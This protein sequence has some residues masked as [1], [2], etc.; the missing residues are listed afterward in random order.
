MLEKI[1]SPHRTFRPWL[2]QRLNPSQ[3][4]P[5]EGPFSPLEFK[6]HANELLGQLFSLDYMGAAE[7]ESGAI[8]RCIQ[9]VAACAEKKFLCTTCKIKVT[10]PHF[11]PLPFGTNEKLEKRWEQAP[12]MF[13]VPVHFLGPK[14]C[15]E[16]MVQWVAEND[17][18]NSSPPL[19]ERTRFQDTTYT[20]QWCRKEGIQPDESHY[21]Y[22][23]WLEISYGVF[24]FL[25]E[26]V[27]QKTCNLF[28]VQN[29][30]TV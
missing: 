20:K 12:D 4:G 5:A 24:Y 9:A 6:K 26:E 7:F 30:K 25:D 29:D 10:K 19:K 21:E 23:G 3:G 2:V 17:A 15:L 16:L 1:E 28:G 18:T 27:F 11:F 8:P 22:I 13:M 14:D